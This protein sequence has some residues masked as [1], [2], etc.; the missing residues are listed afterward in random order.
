MMAVGLAGPSDVGRS[1]W[2]ATE[3]VPRRVGSVT[4]DVESYR[5]ASLETRTATGEGTS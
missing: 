2:L 1:D 4:C 5:D 3:T